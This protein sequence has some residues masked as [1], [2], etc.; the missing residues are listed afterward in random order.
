MKFY[1][2]IVFLLLLSLT[3]MLQACGSSGSGGSSDNTMGSVELSVDKTAV[4]TGSTLTAKLTFSSPSSAPLNG[5]SVNLLSDN[6]DV[7]PNASGITNNAGVANIV[8]QPRSVI[9]TPK[10]ITLVAVVEGI[11]S[12]SVSVTVTP[13]T[14][15]IAPPA[16]SSFA[17]TGSTNDTVRFVAENLVATFKDS[18]GNPVQ[19]QNITLSVTTINNQRTGDQVVFFPTAG[20]KVIAPPGTISVMTD[21]SGTASIPVSIDVVTPSSLGSQHIITII[22]NASADILGYNKTPLTFTASGSTQL[23]VTN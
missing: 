3:L 18:L 17:A 16:N 19:N 12:S 10:T 14:L 1:R 2:F 5:L 11:R 23:T 22:W 21:S 7:I 6:T 13:P 8:L 4:G 20:N 9:T 15:T